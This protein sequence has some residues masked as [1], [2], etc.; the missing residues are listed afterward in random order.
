MKNITLA[1]SCL[2]LAACASTTIY[3]G[4]DNT[5]TSVTTS[6]EQSYAEKDALKRANA[7]CEKMGK[8]LQVLKHESKY[9]GMKKSDQAVLGAISTVLVGMNTARR[10]DDYRVALKFRCK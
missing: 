7:Q 5:F 6:S 10:D 3:P 4:T 1:L 9:Q 8:Q 2:T